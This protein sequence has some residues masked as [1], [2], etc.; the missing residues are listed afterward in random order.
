MAS[1]TSAPRIPVR[2]GP[3]ALDRLRPSCAWLTAHPRFIG[4]F[5]GVDVRKC[6]PGLNSKKVVEA[7]VSGSI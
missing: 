5:H 7:G 3:C 1:L 2:G 4:L 6:L